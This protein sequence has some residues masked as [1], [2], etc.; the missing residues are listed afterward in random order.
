MSLT[1]FTQIFMGMYL[2]NYSLQKKARKENK[3]K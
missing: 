1:M 3:E 2:N